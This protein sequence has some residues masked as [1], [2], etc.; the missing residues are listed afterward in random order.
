MGQVSVAFVNAVPSVT[1]T[2]SATS[3]AALSGV[4]FNWDAN[5]RPCVFSVSG[6]QPQTF[7][8]APTS[9]HASWQDAQLVLGQYVYTIACGTG[10]NGA[11]ASTTVTY[12][13]TPRLSVFQG[14]YAAIAGQVFLVQYQSNLA[15][16]V[17]SG[18]APGDGWSATSMAPYANINVVEST[19]GN[20]TYNIT[21]GTVPQSLQSQTTVTV[22]AAPPQVVIS[23][24]KTVT[25]VGQPVTITWSSNV[26]PCQAMGGSAGD[27]WGGPIASSGS[28][29]VSEATRNLYSYA[30]SCGAPPLNASSMVSVNFLPFGPPSLQ[31]SPTSAQVGQS[32]TLTWSSMDGSSCAA[33]GGTPNDGWATSRDSSGNFQ[34]RETVAGTY[35]YTLTCG[36]AP[37]SSVM[38]TFSPPPPVPLSA[39]PPSVQLAASLA[40]ATVGTPMTLTWTTAN[41]DSC[42]AGGGNSSDGWTGALSPAGGSQNVSESNAGTYAYSITCSETGQSTTAT[43]SATVNVNAAPMVTVSG[44]SGRGGGG[45]V[46]WFELAFLG[47]MLASRARQT[48]AA[49]YQ[50]TAWPSLR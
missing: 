49:R 11:S 19:G 27:G 21:C 7:S 43:S 6:P 18:G 40:T 41:V 17:R 46:N 47:T 34:V 50:P 5:I 20:Y 31:A 48:R 16:C 2:A 30:V 8:S 9:P 44:S 3:I 4:T 45:A 42:T 37:D 12:T 35:T 13:G 33:S 15:P 10:A 36:T 39:P 29:T 23:A 1:L 24:D 14:P 25:G 22:A 26:S 32:V 28:Q 38:I